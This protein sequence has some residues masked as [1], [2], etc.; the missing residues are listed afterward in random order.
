MVEIKS[1][2]D[3]KK[4]LIELGKKN[5]NILTITLDR[6]VEVIKEEIEKKNGKIKKDK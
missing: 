1:F 2:E 4:D 3:R 5:D 6:A